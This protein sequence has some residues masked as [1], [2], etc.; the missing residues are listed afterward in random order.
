MMTGNEAFVSQLV[1]RRAL[2]SATKSFLRKTVLKGPSLHL[3]TL[4]TASR[5]AIEFGESHLIFREI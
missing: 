5:N 3:K 2:L 1:A 4:V